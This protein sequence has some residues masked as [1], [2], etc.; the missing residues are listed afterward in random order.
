MIRINVRIDSHQLWE[1]FSKEPIDKP[2]LVKSSLQQTIRTEKTESSDTPILA[3]TANADPN[4]FE[5]C[6][7]VGMN[8]IITKPIRQSAFITTINNWLS[9]D[10]DAFT[11]EIQTINFQPEHSSKNDNP[12]DYQEGISEFGGDEEIFR[13]IARQFLINVEEQISNL[14][15]ALNRSD[16]EMLYQEA[17]KMHGGAVNLLAMP[18]ARAAQK[19]ENMAKNNDL[20]KI[21]Q[22]IDEIISQWQRL[23]DFF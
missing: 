20:S 1:P 12:I 13:S 10:T 18:L 17:H 4:V 2:D 5:M 19:L 14:K 15:D 21:S 16:N 3:L 11:P 6:R 8:D 9:K 22:T 23:K 7:K